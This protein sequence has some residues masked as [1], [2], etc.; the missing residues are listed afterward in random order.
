MGHP[1]DGGS[2]GDCAFLHVVIGDLNR[3]GKLQ[4]NSSGANP[5]DNRVILR[6]EQD[7]APAA[8][9]PFSPYCSGA[10]ADA[11]TTT[12][13]T[14]AGAGPAL[15]KPA[16]YFGYGVRNSFGMALDPQTGALWM[17]E[18]GPSGI[19][20]VNYV[21]PG[22]NSGWNRLMGLDACDP[23]GLGDLWN[24]PDAGS[25][26]SSSGVPLAHDDRDRLASRCR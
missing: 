2:A 8:S 23:Q 20:E 1:S 3:N 13:P 16:S 5:D 18:N 9:N 24:V 6:V 12:T 14:A 4:N 22:W 15:S 25:T 19:Y 21:P 26:Y 17:T 11:C 7:G 10:T